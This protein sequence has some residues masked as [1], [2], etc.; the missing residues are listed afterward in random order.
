ME[1][2]KKFKNRF[3]KIYNVT[4]AKFIRQ[5]KKAIYGKSF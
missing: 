3:F 2:L 4:Q 5:L 1:L